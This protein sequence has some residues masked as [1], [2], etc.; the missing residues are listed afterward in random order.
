MEVPIIRT[1]LPWEFTLL[2]GNPWRG[3]E[4]SLMRIGNS[5]LWRIGSASSSTKR[6]YAKLFQLPIVKGGHSNRS[7]EVSWPRH[8]LS[9]KPVELPNQFLLYKE[10]QKSGWIWSAKVAVGTALNVFVIIP[11]RDSKRL[12]PLQSGVFLLCPVKCHAPL[13]VLSVCLWFS[14]DFDD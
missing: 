8:L 10:L 2:I 5:D 6:C 1:Y 13:C 4:N 11:P 7:I 12:T 9:I 14:K 3:L